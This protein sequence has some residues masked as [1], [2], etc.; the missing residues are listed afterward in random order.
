MFVVSATGDGTQHLWD[1]IIFSWHSDSTPHARKT[2]HN[3]YM[4]WL[5]HETCHYHAML[6]NYSV[7]PCKQDA[8]YAYLYG[9]IVDKLT[10]DAKN[11]NMDHA[12]CLTRW[13]DSSRMQRSKVCSNA[14]VVCHRRR[15]CRG[16]D[17]TLELCRVLG[18]FAELH[19]RR[20]WSEK[21][22]LICG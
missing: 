8:I 22:V 12:P 15:C 18:I 2:N 16:H 11:G 3:G 10:R 6:C 5:W 20:R 4:V 13:T 14:F 21:S 7:N 9:C 19:Q 17:S 1:N